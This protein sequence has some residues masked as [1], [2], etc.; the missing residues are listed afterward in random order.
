MNM[1]PSLFGYIS[2]LPRAYQISSQFR[3]GV[4]DCL[5]VALAEREGCDLVTSDDRMLKS[6]GTHF[7]FMIAL[8][9]LP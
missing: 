3:V 4:Y 6:L 5:Y 8:T 1:R 7:P 2:L 9:S